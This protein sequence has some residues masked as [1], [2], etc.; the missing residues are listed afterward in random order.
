MDKHLIHSGSYLPR[1]HQ[2]HRM[3]S[4][5]IAAFN[6]PVVRLARRTTRKKILILL[7]LEK[8][9]LSRADFAR[10]LNIGVNCITSPVLSLLKKGELIV[11]RRGLN[12]GT[13][14]QADFVGLPRDKKKEPQK[15]LF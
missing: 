11:I 7:E 1:K 8:D 4:N 14:K 15:R 13:R 6:E 5:S 2:T 9:G 3:H 10:I 12:Q